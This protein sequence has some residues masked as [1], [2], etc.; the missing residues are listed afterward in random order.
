DD[1]SKPSSDDEKKVD[2]DPGKDSESNDQEKE[3]N[4]NITNNV[5][6]A[7]SN[8][9]NDVGAKTCIKLPLD[10]NMPE[11]EDYSIFDSSS[12]DQDDGA[13]ADMN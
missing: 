7:S 1:G 9:V 8:K 3:D 5:N 10:P 2:K 11:Y 4:V 13:E 12:D 6:A